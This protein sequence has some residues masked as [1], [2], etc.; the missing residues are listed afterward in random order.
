MKTTPKECKKEK[1]ERKISD[2]LG[3]NIRRACV[4]RVSSKDYA[5]IPD[6]IE[7]KSMKGREILQYYKKIK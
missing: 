4:L 3:G 7:K 2:Y 6:K 5:Y 1:K